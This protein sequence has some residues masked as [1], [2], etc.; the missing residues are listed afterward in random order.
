M[1]GRRGAEADRIR[2]PAD[3]SQGTEGRA[4][5]PT[6]SEGAVRDATTTTVV[7]DQRPQDTPTTSSASTS[8]T[9]PKRS[10]DATTTTAPPSDR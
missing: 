10:R 2:A 7:T 5:T 1:I 4:D 8:T 6:T 9:E 3:P